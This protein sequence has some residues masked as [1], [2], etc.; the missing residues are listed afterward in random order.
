MFAGI[1]RYTVPPP[2]TKTRTTTNLKTKNN[3]NSQK[4]ELYGSLTTKELEKKYS[5]RPEGRVDM[6]SKGREDFRQGSCWRTRVGKV[7]SGGLGEV[8]AGR[9]GGPTFVCR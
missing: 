6:G 2:T 1:G 9:A 3:H 8:V 5:S 7:G 4:I